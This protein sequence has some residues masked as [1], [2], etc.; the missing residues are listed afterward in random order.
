[1]STRHDMT[2]VYSSLLFGIKKAIQYRINL[3]SWIL[4][5]LSL[6]TATFVSYY[7]LTLQINV[8]GDYS[9]Q[10]MLLYIST[11]FLVNNLYAIFF[12]EAVSVF[13]SSILSGYFQYYLLMP[14]DTMVTVILKNMN[15]PAAVVTP[16]LWLLNIQCLKINGIVGTPIYY[17]SIVTGTLVMGLLMFSI[18]TLALF[19]IRAESLSLVIQQILT[20][21]EKP[22]SVFPKIVRNFL[23][24]LLPIFLLSALP[25]RI[26]LN[27]TSTFEIFWSIL[28]PCLMLLGFAILFRAGLRNY[29]PGME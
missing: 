10:Q 13:G 12:S 14:R 29:E 6:Y 9:S 8:F 27:K 15:I 7:F 1:M 22:D 21:A 26:V 20:T 11:F 24:Y 5:D 3:I 16:F 18:F 17:I 23:T 25:T 4:A 28:A 19:N 2:L